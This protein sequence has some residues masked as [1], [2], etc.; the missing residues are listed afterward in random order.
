MATEP[1]NSPAQTPDSGSSPPDRP[2]GFYYQEDSEVPRELSTWILRMPLYL[3]AGILAIGLLVAA[4]VKIDVV[5]GAPAVLIPEGRTWNLQAPAGAR[6]EAVLAREGER[7][8]RGQVLVRFEAEAQ[9]EALAA[10]RKE[11]ELAQA[12]VRDTQNGPKREYLRH[13][14]LSVLETPIRTADLQ[15]LVVQYSRAKLDFSEAN[16]MLLEVVPQ[17]TATLRGEQQALRKKL[18]LMDSIQSRGKNVRAGRAAE[19]EGQAASRELEAAQLAQDLKRAQ[20]HLATQEAFRARKLVTEDEVRLAQQEVRRLQTAVKVARGEAQRL[21]QS[22]GVARDE[23]STQLDNQQIDVASTEAA[24]KQAESR[25]KRLQSDAEGE[26]RKARTGL[27]DTAFL[28]RQRLDELQRLGSFTAPADGVLT[29]MNVRNAGEVVERG[30]LIASLAPSQSALNAELTVANKD[31]GMIR[32]GMKVKFKLH[33]YP[34]Q[35][36]GVVRGEV[37]RMPQDTGEQ[38]NHFRVVATLDSQSIRTGPS[39]IPLRYGLAATAEIITQRRSLL[40]VLIEPLR[41]RPRYAQ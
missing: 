13:D 8:K 32:E 21:K 22:A 35:D 15:D 16:R 38:I 27:A 40:W 20:E 10:L 4:I 2:Q 31:I 14:G 37:I 30:A 11:V 24:L 29:A 33:A 1:S 34:Y 39:E 36:F 28:L 3:T 17:E 19:Y 41:K 25:A 9:P 7:V 26:F 12:A 18:A 5:I 23:G 6:V